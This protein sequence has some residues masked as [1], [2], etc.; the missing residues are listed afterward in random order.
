MLYINY[1]K[2]ESKKLKNLSYKKSLIGKDIARTGK[3]GAES[4]G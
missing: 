1:K 2:E 3:S 4:S